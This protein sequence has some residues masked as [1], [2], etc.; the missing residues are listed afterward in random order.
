ME[1]CTF[2]LNYN[3]KIKL[4]G[5]YFVSTITD[6]KTI[7]LGYNNEV[8]LERIRNETNSFFETMR[9]EYNNHGILPDRI[10]LRYNFNNN[11]LV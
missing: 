3:K 4:N 1:N 11:V 9:L 5:E 8:N 7:E 10:E 6:C 2:V